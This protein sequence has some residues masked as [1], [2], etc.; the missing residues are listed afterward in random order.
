M[1]DDNCQGTKM[2]FLQI[3][4]LLLIS[5]LK[6]IM[7]TK[8]WINVI[9]KNY[10]G[11]LYLIALYLI[12]VFLEFIIIPKVLIHCIEIF[13]LPCMTTSLREVYPRN[14]NVLFNSVL[15][16]IL[17]QG[18]L[19]GFRAACH[20]IVLAMHYTTYWARRIH[21]MPWVSSSVPEQFK[22]VPQNCYICSNSL[23]KSFTIHIILTNYFAQK[24]QKCRIWIHHETQGDF[25]NMAGI[26]LGTINIH[27]WEKGEGLGDAT[28]AR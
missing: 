2:S 19:F 13:K 16:C 14:K 17:N 15:E 11:T 20:K 28:A 21:D 4:S 7:L 24:K 3:S 18:F 5:S 1:P 12:A 8:F 22:S 26:W 23:Q 10:T 6:K 27:A 9:Q 25:M